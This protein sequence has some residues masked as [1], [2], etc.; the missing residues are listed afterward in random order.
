MTV[1]KPGEPVNPT[2][3][4]K[5]LRWA[6]NFLL[7]YYGLKNHYGNRLHRI[8]NA[9]VRESGFPEKEMKKILVLDDDLELCELLTDYLKGEGFAVEVNRDPKELLEK[10]PETYADLLILD[11]M[12]PEINGFEVLKKIRA[13]SSVPII[14]LTARGEELDRVLGLE[15][16]A[17]DYLPKPFSPRELVA[18]IRAIFRRAEAVSAGNP[19]EVLQVGDLKMVV[20]SRR[21]FRGQEE[22][23]LTG[24][25]FRLLELLLR[26]P[27]KTQKRQDLALQALDRH[28]NYEDRSLDVHISNLRKKIGSKTPTGERI[29]TVWG[30]GY[31]LAMLQ[32]GES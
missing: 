17:D 1:A 18:R 31:V 22:I 30:V 9:M 6:Y 28:L 11:V 12:L 3:C 20:G 25:E 8:G 19:E 15:L 10:S 5:R 7:I 21:V 14:M 26:S 24:V 29:Q 23:S 13:R 32:N 16:G 4:K 2:L 27:G